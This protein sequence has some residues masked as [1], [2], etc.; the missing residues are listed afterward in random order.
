M[1]IYLKIFLSPRFFPFG[2]FSK[3]AFNSIRQ[4]L[5]EKQQQLHTA[6]LV[7]ILDNCEKKKEKKLTSSSFSSTKF[8]L[9]IR[10]ESVIIYME[11]KKKKKIKEK[12]IALLPS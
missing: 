8:N 2:V 9:L 1:L 7:R 12:F 10:C 5:R 11:E 3:L 4:Q 6:V